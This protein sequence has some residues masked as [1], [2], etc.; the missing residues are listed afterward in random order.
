MKLTRKA[1]FIFFAAF[2]LF[3]GCGPSKAQQEAQAAAEKARTDSIARAE[4]IA[5]QRADSIEKAKDAEREAEF[6]AK[7]QADSIARAKLLPLF[8]ETKNAGNSMTVSYQI[9]GTPAGHTQNSVYLSCNVIDGRTAE[10]VC[11]VDCCGADW[12]NPTMAVFTIGDE[13][14]EVTPTGEQKH[15]VND[16]GSC[17]E[18]FSS[19]SLSSN[20]LEAI[21]EAKS[22]T[23]KIVGE[24][25]S[26]TLKLSAKDIANMR[27]TIQLSRLF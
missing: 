8:K 26:K 27:Q 15:N 3:A 1:I 18:W 25:G 5:R 7:F 12:I 14:Y 9:K 11:N 19:T 20:L 2:G 16:N 24:D 4:E 23:V 22:C 10:L 13:N 21:M 17:S 6:K